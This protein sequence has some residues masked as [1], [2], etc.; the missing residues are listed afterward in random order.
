M[1]QDPLASFVQAQNIDA[2]IATPEVVKEPE[3]Q[4]PETI[5]APIVETPKVEVKPTKPEVEEIVD[6]EI[7]YQPPKLHENKIMVVADPKELSSIGTITWKRLRF[8][9]F[10]ERYGKKKSKPKVMAKFIS[11]AILLM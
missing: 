3:A 6:L 7:G 10:W 11:L 8:V 1:K 9:E 4:A 2:E 5:E